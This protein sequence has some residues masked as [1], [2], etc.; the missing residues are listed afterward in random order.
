MVTVCSASKVSSLQP[1][2]EPADHSREKAS[3]HNGLVKDLQHLA[4]SHT[5]G[6]QLHQEIKTLT[7]SS[8][9]LC[10]WSSSGHSKVLSYQGCPFTPEIDMSITSLS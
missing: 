5:E 4:A 9:Q 10:C 7:S 3:G 8:T 1:I 6:P 2:T